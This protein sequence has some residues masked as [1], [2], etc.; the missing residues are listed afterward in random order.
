VSAKIISTC[1]GSAKGPS[2]KGQRLTMFLIK[3]SFGQ[4]ITSYIK[5]NTQCWTLEGSHIINWNM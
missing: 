3:K 5:T 1:S 2:S 4:A